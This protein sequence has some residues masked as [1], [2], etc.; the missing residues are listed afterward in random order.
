MSTGA[1]YDHHERLVSHM[2]DAIGVDL[3]A[4]VQAGKIQPE[5]IDLQ[6]FNCMGCPSPEACKDWVD[7]HGGVV[8]AAPD[9]CRNKETLERLA[10]K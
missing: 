2:A 7:A 6:V 8:K 4:S 3:E 1:R 10:R 9:Y 5:E